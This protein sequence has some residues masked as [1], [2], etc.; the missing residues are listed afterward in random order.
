MSGSKAS[1]AVPVLII[2]VG[3]GWLLTTQHVIPGVDWVWVLGLGVGGILTMA[4]AGID[5]VTIVV[6][7]FLIISTFFSLARQTGRLTVDTE[8]P[9]LVILAGVLALLARVVNVPTPSWIDKEDE[10]TAG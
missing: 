2:A 1:V 7:P 5:K 8:V 4:L 6:G 10:P 3:T 9:C